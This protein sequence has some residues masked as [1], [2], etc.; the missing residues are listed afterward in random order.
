MQDTSELISAIR[1]VC[2]E[3]NISYDS[4]IAT[5]EAAL[6]A[7]YRKDFGEKNQ[8]IVV[9]F[10]AETGASKVYDVKNVVPDVDLEEQEKQWEAIK[11]RR[12]AGE[13]IPESEDVKRF[14]PKTEIMM[15]EAQKIKK[16]IAMGDEVK[17]R[18]TVPATYGRM[19]AQTAKQVIIQRIR[20][21]ERENI[22]NEFKGREGEIIN[23]VVQ[24]VEGPMVLFDVG[25]TTAVMPPEHQVRRERYE[26]GRRMKV[27]LAAVTMSVRGAQVVISR[28]SEQFVAKLFEHEVPEIASGLV[29]I[30]GI[31]REPGER[32]K[33]AVASTEDNIDPVGSCV[34]QRGTRVQTVIGELGGEKIDI[35]DWSEDIGSLIENSISP[36]KVI[37]V[38][39]NAEAKQAVVKVRED[40]LSLAIGKGG[41][42]VRLASRLTGYRLDIAKEDGT[43][44]SEQADGEKVPEA[45]Q[46][47]EGAAIAGEGVTPAAASEGETPAEGATPVAETAEAVEPAADV[48]K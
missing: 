46:A 24:R 15:S 1:Q 39:V 35:I 12:E 22:F 18:L 32:S 41:Q 10:D 37:N 5:I 34:G 17:T 44:Q 8:N 48:T 40:Q 29:V 13:E 14:N 26:S 25:A 2:D 45:D 31:A 19:A 16:D 38:T 42:N 47:S 4:V 33:V 23:A 20:E 6:A 27:L 30:K 9:E 11:T 28:A 43:I 21:A 7:A 3:K 36:A